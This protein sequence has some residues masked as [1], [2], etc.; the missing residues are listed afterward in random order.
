MNFASESAL[1]TALDHWG[2]TLALVAS[3][4]AALIVS[5]WGTAFSMFAVWRRSDTFTHGYLIVPI[6]A[7][8][9]W[10]KRG[11]IA[12][13]K[14][15]PEFLPLT[16]LAGFALVWLVSNIAGILVLEQ[17]AFVMMAPALIWVLLGQ[18]VTKAL[19][20]PLFFLLF[21]VPAGE[22]LTPMLMELT[23][24]VTVFLLG[25]SG[26]P[27]YREGLF[28]SIPS[29]KWS[30]VEACSGLRD[31]IASV[32][33]GCLFAYLA[34][35]SLKKRVI[36]IV[37]AVLV[38]IV[39]NCLRAYL[40]VM[41]GHLSDMKLATGV[42]H[43]VYGWL[44]FGLVIAALFWVG[45]RYRDERSEAETARAQSRA[46]AAPEKMLLAAAAALGITSSAPAYAAYARHPVVDELPIL[47]APKEQGGWQ[48]IAEPAAFTPHFLQ[49]RASLQQSYR[50]GDA[51]IGLFIA[52]YKNQRE[53]GEMIS[54]QNVIVT[55]EDSLLRKTAESPIAANFKMNSTEIRNGDSRLV[56]W[57]WYWV[58]RTHTANPYWAKLLQVQSELV[59]SRDDSAVVVI[60]AP[61]DRADSLHD[62]LHSID[63]EGVLNNASQE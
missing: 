27:V 26:I 54:S 39:G 62:F 30:V 6:S 56:V 9:I 16:L 50:K 58:N 31:L 46:R 48:K 25:A 57:H 43:L 53:H 12:L 29:G 22:I 13:L 32:T 35:Q 41:I 63:I 3:C 42:D 51:V 28:F 59:H 21:A 45:S 38:P 18:R 61:R 10:A 34:Y 33:L 40:I 55:N 52:Y 49:F 17:Y 44:F 7:Y 2:W 47:N 8:L 24:D 1:S 5:Y 11:A 4:I 60:H 36:F 20:F 14:P 23:A 15:A 19:A 37:A